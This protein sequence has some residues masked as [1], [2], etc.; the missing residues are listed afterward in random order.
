MQFKSDGNNGNLIFSAGPPV[1]TMPQKI[2]SDQF[3][4]IQA[5][6]KRQDEALERL[7]ELDA[8]VELA[9]QELIGPPQKAGEDILLA[10]AA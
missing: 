3:E 9:I 10:D 1:A 6:L 5:L 2:Q 7:E 8:R 4:T